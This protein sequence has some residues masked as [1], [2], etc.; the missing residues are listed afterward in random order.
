MRDISME[1]VNETRKNILEIIESATL[2]HEQKLT[3]L[4]NQADSLMEVLDLPEGLDE[5]LNVPIDRKH[6]S[7][8]CPRDMRLC[9]PVTLFRIMRNS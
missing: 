7:A 9:V 2:T 4:A 8:I 6:V 3:C 5:L 1:R